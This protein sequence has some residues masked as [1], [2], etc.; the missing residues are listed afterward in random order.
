ME[1]FGLDDTVKMVKPHEYFR[2][3]NAA[4]L[5]GHE[6]PAAYIAPYP[7]GSERFCGVKRILRLG[8]WK[9]WGERAWYFKVEGDVL[10]HKYDPSWHRLLVVVSTPEKKA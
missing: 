1:E 2:L 4:R 5:K 9:L 8:E 3:C 7:E 6:E 10:L